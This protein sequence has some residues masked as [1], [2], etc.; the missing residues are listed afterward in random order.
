M[1]AP[2]SKRGAIRHCTPDRSRLQ[3]LLS[4]MNL[5]L[6]KG[7]NKQQLMDDMIAFCRGRIKDSLQKPQDDSKEALVSVWKILTEA[8][9]TV[10]SNDP[11]HDKLICLLLWTGEFDVL[12]KSLHPEEIHTRSSW[13]CHHLVKVMQN[14]WKELIFPAHDTIE[15][16]CSLATFTAKALAMGT[17]DWLGISAL[18]YLREALEM[19]DKATI[20]LAPSTI[21]WIRI[22]GAKLLRFSVL[23]KKWDNHDLDREALDIVR[24]QT[25]GILAQRA[26]VTQDGFSLE[27]WFFW[28]GRFENLAPDEDE[29][30]RAWAKD[31]VDYMTEFDSM[32]DYN[33]KGEPKAVDDSQDAVSE[34]V[35]NTKQKRLDLRLL[36]R[37]DKEKNGEQRVEVDENF[38]C[39]K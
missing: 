9:Q 26:G 20:H 28:K 37:G 25:P 3:D 31:T 38:K 19:A 6:F 23:E 10:E 33:M 32:L 16:K 12:R 39:Q 18:W 11:F 30:S 22:A 21:I 15:K 13:E 27:R 36:S 24:I 34:K 17:H 29:E 4:K 5:N 35:E 2:I 14:S 1:V 7:K 8:A